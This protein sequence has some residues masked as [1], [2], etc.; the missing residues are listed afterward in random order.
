VVLAG[1]AGL[2]ARSRVLDDAAPTL[3][4]AGGGKAALGRLLAKLARQEI[5]SVLVEGGARVHGAFIAAGLVDRVALFV[6]PRLLGG[7]V[8]IATGADLP[9]VRGLELGPIAAR[10]VGG[11]LLLTA[12]VMR[13]SRREP[14][15]GSLT[16]PR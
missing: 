5:Q 11:D 9:V 14:S 15:K 13:T 3:V 8:P 16:L 6:A 7:G 12:D 4:V 1:R 2:P 10:A